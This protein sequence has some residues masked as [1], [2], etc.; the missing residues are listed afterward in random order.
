MLMKVKITT[1]A[2]AAATAA[3]AAAAAAAKSSALLA[4]SLACLHHASQRFQMTKTRQKLNKTICEIVWVRL[5]L[6]TV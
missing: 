2:A 3:V 5:M 1:A 4:S 6:A